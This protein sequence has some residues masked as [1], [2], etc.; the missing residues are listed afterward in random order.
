MHAS[1]YFLMK[2]KSMLLQKRKK[3]KI[4]V[5]TGSIFTIPIIGLLMHCTPDSVD[6][7]F[8][9]RSIKAM[10]HLSKVPFVSSTTSLFLAA[11]ISAYHMLLLTN[12]SGG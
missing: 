7:C 8:I 11:T 6:T 2:F 1:L 10:S 5:H 9:I 4:Q 12:I 3:K